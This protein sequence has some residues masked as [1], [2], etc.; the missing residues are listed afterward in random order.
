MVRKIYGTPKFPTM[1]ILYLVKRF[2]RRTSKF[3]ECFK[4]PPRPLPDKPLYATQHWRAP[5]S[6]SCPG[7]HRSSS[8][9]PSP[10]PDLDS[11]I[12][13]SSLTVGDVTRSFR[14]CGLHL[15][16]RTSH[17]GRRAGRGFKGCRGGRRSVP[18]AT[19]SGGFVNHRRSRAGWRTSGS[20]PGPRSKGKVCIS[21]RYHLTWR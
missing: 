7:Y 6:V 13:I 11:A 2:I 9:V 15:T 5:P 8:P 16:R 1:S 17:P 18:A 3:F 19:M 14:T 10:V 12:R 21:E 20:L 4:H